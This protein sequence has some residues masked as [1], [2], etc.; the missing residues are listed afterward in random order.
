MPAGTLS[1]HRN[2][3]DL[4][5]LFAMLDAAMY[6]AEL[7][8]IVLRHTGRR[9]WGMRR[10]GRAEV[11]KRAAKTLFCQRQGGVRVGNHRAAHGPQPECRRPGPRMGGQIPIFV[12]LPS[13]RQSGVRPQ[14]W[15][16]IETL[17]TTTFNSQQLRSTAFEGGGTVTA[18]RPDRRS[19]HN[20]SLAGSGTINNRVAHDHR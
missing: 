6:K 3:L 14:L 10:A 5:I 15:P 2:A 16:H 13:P 20:R 9:G 8:A 11:N 1:P 4:E 18:R 12:F 7:H 17:P 19:G